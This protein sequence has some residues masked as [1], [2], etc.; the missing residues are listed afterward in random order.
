MICREKI[1]RLKQTF[2]AESSPESNN[3]LSGKYKRQNRAYQSSY[4]FTKNKKTK[5]PEINTSYLQSSCKKKI[6]QQQAAINQKSN[7]KDAIVYKKVNTI[8]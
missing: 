5:K 2:T 8:Y 6:A 1:L 3:Y 7:Q 4:Q